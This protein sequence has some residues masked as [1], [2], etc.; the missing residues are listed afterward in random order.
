M[1]RKR[2]VGTDRGHEIRTT[3]GKAKS[4]CGLR[5]DEVP[6]TDLGEGGLGDRGD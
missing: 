4:L 1:S 3:R 5:K 6:V 2:G